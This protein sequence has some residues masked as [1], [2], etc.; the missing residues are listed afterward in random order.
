MTHEPKRAVAQSDELVVETSGL[1]KSYKRGQIKAVDELDLQ[2][3][4]RTVHGFLGPNGSGKTTTIRMLLGLI[5]PDSGR[6][7]IFGEAIPQ[8][9][10]EIINRVGAIVETPKFF[11]QFSATKNL[12]ILAEGVGVPNT[13]VDEVL[14]RV[15]MSSR[16]KDPFKGYSL[17]MKQRV[18]VAAT[19][20]K[21]PELLIFD[22]P[23]NG[24]DPAGI[25]EIRQTM[26]QLADEG[27][28]VIVSSHI[29]AEVQQIADTCTIIGNGQVL[30]AGDVSEL[31]AGET[32]NYLIRPTDPMLAR[33]VLTDAGF[34]VTD[35]EFG[36]LRVSVTDRPMNPAEISHRLGL[37]NV[38]LTEMI[39]D[40]PSL[41]QVFLRLTAKTQLKGEAA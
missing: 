35:T 21:D 32:S 3:P 30:A 28:T 2:V 20:L 7:R 34:T 22:E 24:L 4:A 17:G 1:C 31:L 33:Q 14:E 18:A 6:A 8:A 36:Q 40:R 11:P 10:P 9:L 39:E 29:L 26:R 15:G 38:W 37:A 27:K 23:T 19:L 41:E 12:Q 25:H 5:R 16:A 13:R